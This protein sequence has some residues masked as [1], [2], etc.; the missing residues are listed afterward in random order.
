MPS[1]LRWRGARAGRGREPEPLPEP[2]DEEEEVEEEA[3]E[4]AAPELEPAAADALPSFSTHLNL[5]RV[6]VD[7]IQTVYL[8]VRRDCAP[9]AA[10]RAAGGGGG[11]KGG[12]A[13]EAGVQHSRQAATQGC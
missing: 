5:Q 12:G 1:A 9:I 10:A 7:Q 4:E 6:F 2:E 13:L 3:E 11:V 8:L